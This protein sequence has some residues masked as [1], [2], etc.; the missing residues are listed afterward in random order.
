MMEIAKLEA[1]AKAKAAEVAILKA[2]LALKDANEGASNTQQGGAGSNDNKD[3]DITDSIERIIANAE[4]QII[5]ENSIVDSDSDSSPAP[6]LDDSEFDILPSPPSLV[7][8]SS[9]TSEAM[10]VIINLVDPPFIIRQSSVPSPSPEKS[11]LEYTKLELEQR[12]ENNI[13]SK[14]NDGIDSTLELLYT[15]IEDCRTKLMDPNSSMDDQTDAAQLMT[16]YAK[17][18]QAL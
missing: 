16:Q 18:A 2:K 8:E 11:T 6:S 1:E 12:D 17:S 4:S 10:P 15:K 9:D 3:V 7:Y 5:L 13:T 14:N